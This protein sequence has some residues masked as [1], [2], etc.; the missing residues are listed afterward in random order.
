MKASWD[1][2]GL[3]ATNRK[4]F[5]SGRNGL[6]DTL[7]TGTCASANQWPMTN[8]KALLTHWSVHQNLNRV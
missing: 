2:I 6:S 4:E 1:D 8:G 3:T 5:K 7:L